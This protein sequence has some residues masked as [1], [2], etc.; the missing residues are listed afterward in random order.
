MFI[1][2]RV[3]VH[4]TS[5]ATGIALKNSVHAAITERPRVQGWALKGD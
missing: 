4:L 1:T 2:T 5:P 3:T